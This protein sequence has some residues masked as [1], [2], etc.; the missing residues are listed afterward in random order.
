[1]S[2]QKPDYTKKSPVLV[3]GAT[4]YVAG[5]LVKRL[6]EE[7]VTVHAAVRDPENAEKIAHLKALDGAHPGS[8]KYFKADLLDEGSFDEAMAGCEIVFHTASPFTSKITDPQRD[9]VDPAVKGTRNV[10]EAVNRTPSVT[11]VVVTSSCASIYGDA[12][13]VAQSKD[14]IL[15]EADWNTT[16]RLDHQAYSF[17][18]VEAEKAA[19]ALADAQDRWKLVTINPSLVLGPGVAKQQTSESFSLIKQLGDGTSKAGVPKFEIGVV[20]VRDVAE[21][22]LLAGYLENAEGRYITSEKT[23][24]FLEIGGA[25]RTAFGDAYPFPKGTIPKWLIWLVGPFINKVYAREMIAKNMGHP[26]QAD[27]SKSRRDLG[28]E[29]HSG[30]AAVVEMFQQM[31]DNGVVK[32]S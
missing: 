11:R 2:A 28:L 26:W 25:L 19:W 17:S 23:M 1:M 32:K 9:L 24:S 31:I 13:D 27:N 10:L 4:G 8:I 30:A 3:T 15:T 14:G 21:A 7:G 22:H 18:K 29:Y 20:D 16:S 5:W 6:V 12:I